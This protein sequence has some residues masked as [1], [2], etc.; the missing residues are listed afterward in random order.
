MPLSTGTRLGP[1]EI[2]APLG[3]GGMGEVYKAQFAGTSAP[4]DISLRADSTGEWIS[5]DG[6]MVTIS[7]QSTSPNTAYLTKRGAAP[8]ALGEGQS[9]GVSRAGQTRA[10]PN[11]NKLVVDA[12]AWLPDGRRVILFDQPPGKPS[13]GY[14]QDIDG[15]APKAFTP[16]GRA[17]RSLVGGPGVAGWFARGC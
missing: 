17:Q 14:V 12:A 16:E 4:V 6:K 3:A 7:D 15:G 8:V 11:P 5:D 10:L 2:L 13:R 1:Y 9:Y